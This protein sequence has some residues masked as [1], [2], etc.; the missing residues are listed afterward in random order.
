MFLLPSR[1]LKN[2]DHHQLE[3]VKA[4]SITQ[5][6][7]GIYVKYQLIQVFDSADY[8]QYHLGLNRNHFSVIQL[9]RLMHIT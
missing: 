3:E 6:E 5:T 7:R 9:V 2:H 1:N 4:H 8:P